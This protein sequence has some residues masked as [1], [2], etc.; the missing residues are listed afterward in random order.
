MVK[1]EALRRLRDERADVLFVTTF[2]AEQNTAMRAVNAK[3]GFVPVTIFT[4]AVLEL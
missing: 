3:L 2:N 1:C 4:S